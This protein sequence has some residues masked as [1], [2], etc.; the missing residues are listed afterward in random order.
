MSRAYRRIVAASLG[1]VLLAGCG[2]GSTVD[3]PA[4]GGA[5]LPSLTVGYVS[6]IDQLGMPVGLEQGF[7]EEAGLDV[8]LSQPF[9]TGVDALNALQAGEADVI[10]VGTPAIAAAQKGVDLVLVGNYTGSASK[11]SIDDTM[12]VVAAGSAGIDGEDLTTLRGKRIGVSVGS[13]NHLYLLGLLNSAGLVPTDVEIVNTAPPDMAVALQ[14]GG[15]DAAVVW[16]PWPL[17]IADQVAGSTEVLRGGGHVP[18]V[19]Y[20]VTT[21]EYAEANP[22]VLEGLLT[23]R[24]Q[25]DEWMRANPDDAA[26]S[27]TRWLPGIEPDVAKAAMENNLAQLDPRFSA[28]NY[29]ALDTVARLL[30]EQGAAEAGFDVNDYLAPAAM[31]AVMRDNPA[32][33]EDLPAVPEQAAIEDGYTYE[34][35]AATGACPS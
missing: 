6:A 21:R 25:A 19:G 15:I 18:Y 4:E 27:A 28:C 7:F 23:A 1:V 13:I 3:D 9:P 34:R 14:T 33:F 20:I 22:S 17:V 31:L 32:L 5:A 30:A 12:A 8:T 35:D 10:Q 16:D 24:A 11:L 26:E 2:D 29:L